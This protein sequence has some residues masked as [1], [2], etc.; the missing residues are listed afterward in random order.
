MKKLKDKSEQDLEFDIFRH[1]KLAITLGIGAS[2]GE[3]AL[4]N[5]VPRTASVLCTENTQF[6]VLSMESYNKI[7]KAFDDYKFNK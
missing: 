2:F 4:R 3:I 7:M 5:M 6:A 1:S